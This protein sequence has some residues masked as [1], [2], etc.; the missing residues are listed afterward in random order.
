MPLAAQ[1]ADVLPYDSLATL[2]ALGRAPLG[3][4]GLAVDAPRVA[5]LLDMRHALRERVAALGAEEVPVV[6]VLP[7]RHHMFTQDRRRA[8]LAAGGEELVPVQVAI[9]AEALVAVFGHC[10]AGLLLEALAGGAALDALQ[11]GGAVQVWLGADL[12]GFEGGPADVAGEALGVEALVGAGESYEPSLDGIV[13][14]VAAG[15]GSVADLAGSCWSPVAS[16]S[17]T[18]ADFGGSFLWSR[19]WPG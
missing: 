5:V 16:W 6:P 8:V 11:A 18:R 4:L 15:S 14:F 13:A 1:G 3:A 2:L 10:L 9:E 19:K 12:E 7:E 17:A